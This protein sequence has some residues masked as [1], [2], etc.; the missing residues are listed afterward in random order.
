MKATIATALNPRYPSS[1]PYAS[2]AL[3]LPIERTENSNNLFL[4]T[5]YNVSCLSPFLTSWFAPQIGVEAT[6][7]DEKHGGQRHQRVHA[8]DAQ[9]Y[10]SR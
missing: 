7:I 4:P 8:R 1:R 5:R 2:R 6:Y 9:P 3:M 10:Q